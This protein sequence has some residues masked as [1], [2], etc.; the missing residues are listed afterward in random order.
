MQPST[1]AACVARAVSNWARWLAVLGLDSGS[2]PLDMGVSVRRSADPATAAD[3]ESVTKGERVKIRVT[4][5]ALTSIYVI[6]LDLASV[7]TV[8]PIYPR[9]ETADV[10]VPGKTAEIE[11][12]AMLPAG[13]NSGIDHIKVIAFAQPSNAPVSR[14]VSPSVFR[15][16][17]CDE[18]ERGA[19]GAE[20]DL[21]RLMRLS[22][23]GSRGPAVP[24]DAWTV[25]HLALRVQPE[26]TK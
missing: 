6:I 5:K 12:T 23:R 24:V 18:P 19:R 3:A 13:R 15:L 16:Q 21:E 20:D 4:N 25:R 11:V 2:S 7:G 10:L 9:G 1:S 26:G 22:S 8:E 14:Q 17:P